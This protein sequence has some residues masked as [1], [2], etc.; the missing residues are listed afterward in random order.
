MRQ[1]LR[2]TLLM[3]VAG[4]LLAACVSGGPQVG[5]TVT[6]C[7]PGNYDNYRAYGLVLRDMPGFLS[8]YMVAEFDT[9]LQEKGLVR[10]DR[11]NDLTVTMS[12]RHVNLN[13]EQEEIDPFE[14]RI[15]GEPMLRY[16]ANIVVEMRES[17]TG[18]EV[19]AGRI[20][21]IHTVLPG[22]Y[23]HEDGAR[24]EISHAFTEMLESYPA[25]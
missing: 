9:A 1:I 17:D 11:L 8:D 21:R 23:M 25:L 14:R 3:M 24:P 12:Y 10:N 20:S 16:V 2:Q 19:W 6:L 22:E 18:R 5:H 15:E 4:L 7:C 13:P